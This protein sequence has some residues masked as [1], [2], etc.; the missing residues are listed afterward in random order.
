MA[1]GRWPSLLAVVA[2]LALVAFFSVRAWHQWSYA[3][4]VESGS[5]QVEDLRGWMTL[6]YVEKVYKV[7]Q[8][9]VRET[10]GLPASGFEERSLKDWF[11]A[12]GQDP[13]AGRRKVEALI[14]QSAPAAP[15]SP[16]P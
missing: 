12:T 15:Y 13:S 6:A 8:S 1:R 5:V 3:Q 16:S 11:D 9:R 2:G 7:P 4:R 14:L 10:L